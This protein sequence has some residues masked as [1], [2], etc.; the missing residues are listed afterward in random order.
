MGCRFAL[1]SAGVILGHNRLKISV[2]RSAAN[3]EQNTCGIAGLQ[4]CSYSQ[5]QH[6]ARICFCAVVIEKPTL[7]LRKASVAILYYARCDFH[8]ELRSAARIA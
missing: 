5:H 3:L 4:P 1:E 6:R 7:P 8:Q 2:M